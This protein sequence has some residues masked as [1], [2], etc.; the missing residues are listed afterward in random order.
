M[1]RP[2]ANETERLNL[3]QQYW[4]NADGEI[5]H[6]YGF[7]AMFLGRFYDQDQA[8]AFAEAMT[9]A[10]PLIKRLCEALELFDLEGAWP[11][12]MPVSECRKHQAVI[13]AA[14]AE[15]TEWL[16]QEGAK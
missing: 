6:K 11:D 4:I 15:G 10:A 16:K 14:L 5:N 1:T 8:R 13:D 12:Q 2:M 9:S 7:E 3:P